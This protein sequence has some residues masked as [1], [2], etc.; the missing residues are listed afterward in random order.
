MTADANR[1]WMTR[2]RTRPNDDVTLV[3]VS[4]KGPDL[5]LGKRLTV[6]IAVES[7]GHYCV[8]AAVITTARLKA[9]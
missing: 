7:R 8:V 4:M 1:V 6:G 9:V 2:V 5:A 3:I